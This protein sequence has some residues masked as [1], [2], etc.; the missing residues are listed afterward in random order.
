[1]TAAT[2]ATAIEAAAAV[3]AAAAAAQTAAAAKEQPRPIDQCQD[4]QALVSVKAALSKLQISIISGYMATP[5][6]CGLARAAA[7]FEVTRPF[8]QEQ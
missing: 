8:G 2:E 1:M 7:V 6:V 3:A 4:T 5:V